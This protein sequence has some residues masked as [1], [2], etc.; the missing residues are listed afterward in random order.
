MWIVAVLHVSACLFPWKT[1]AIPK[2]VFQTHQQGSTEPGPEPAL[3]HPPPCRRSLRA[4]AGS[5]AQKT[6]IMES[7]K[8]SYLFRQ[9]LGKESLAL[10]NQ[11]R[12]GGVL[13][14]LWLCS[15]SGKPD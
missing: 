7:L 6:L 13:A 8:L 4:R 3:L 10:G 14:V 12:Q 11:Q 1:C 9:E 2:R 15:D 5:A